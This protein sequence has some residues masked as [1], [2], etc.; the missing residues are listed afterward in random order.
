MPAVV[1]DRMVLN[2]AIERL[3]MQNSADWSTDAKLLVDFGFPL[4]S[5][6]MIRIEKNYSRS[7]NDD[8]IGS[9]SHHEDTTQFG[10]IG[11]YRIAHF[12]DIGAIQIERRDMRA[13]KLE[14]GD[15]AGYQIRY[16]AQEVPEVFVRLIASAAEPVAAIER[17]LWLSR[18]QFNAATL[19][20]RVVRRVLRPMAPRSVSYRVSHRRYFRF[21][22]Q[23]VFSE[24]PD[25][26]P[27]VVYR[28]S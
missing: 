13:Q 27:G 20:R 5:S 25:Y 16:D 19:A 26:I 10:I 28:G 3:I 1:H 14:D 11:N 21:L 22:Y 24:N 7:A 6:D 2:A 18:L 15:V 9:V 8:L 12:A 17:Q 4:P 23:I